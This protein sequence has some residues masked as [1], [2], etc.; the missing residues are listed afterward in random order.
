MIPIFTSAISIFLHGGIDR[1]RDAHGEIDRFEAILSGDDRPLSL[2]HTLEERFELRAQRLLLLDGDVERLD[3]FSREPVTLHF[4]FA[5]IDGDVG[6]AA[7]EA[8]LAH[9]ILRNA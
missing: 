3:R 7:E 1:C 9:A 2:A 6:I 4:L 8:D 5:R